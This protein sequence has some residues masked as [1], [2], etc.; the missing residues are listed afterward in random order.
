MNYEVDKLPVSPRKNRP[1]KSNEFFTWLTTYKNSGGNNIN[2][3]YEVMKLVDDSFYY[4]GTTLTVEEV[5]EA[6][7]PDF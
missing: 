4:P 5:R 7:K 1:L 2:T 6:N 3:I